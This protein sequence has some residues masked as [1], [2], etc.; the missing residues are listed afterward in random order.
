MKRLVA[1]LF[2]FV[3][4][5]ACH[6]NNKKNTPKDHQEN[7]D[8]SGRENEG[9]KEKDSSEANL[10]SYNWSKKEQNKFLEDCKRESD[11]DVPAEKVKDFCSC[12]LLQ[13]QKYYST[14]SKMD[15]N[16]NEDDDSKIFENCMD[17]LE[18]DDQ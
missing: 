14:Y 3:L 16:S 12:M 6:T 15:K 5:T 9:T 8:S 2:A 4:L 13:A 18:T 17:H 1:L 11:Q 7:T 10:K